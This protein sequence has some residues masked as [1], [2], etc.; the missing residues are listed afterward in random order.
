MNIN[1]YLQS[2]LYTYIEVSEMIN[3]A[4]SQGKNDGAHGI[5][6]NLMIVHNTITGLLFDAGEIDEDNNVL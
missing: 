3:E 5:S 4:Y 6:R 2:R 1:Q